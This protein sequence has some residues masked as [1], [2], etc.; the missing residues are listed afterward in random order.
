MSPERTISST[1]WAMAI[2][3]GLTATDIFNAGPRKL[4]APRS[5]VAIG[6]LW[7]ILHL[8]AGGRFGRLAAQLSLLIVLAAIVLGPFGA[9]LVSFLQFVGQ[10]FSLAPASPGGGASSPSTPSPGQNGVLA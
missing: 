9:V 4:P 1:F 6:V 5:F 7:S 8:L 3:R 2:I 10:R